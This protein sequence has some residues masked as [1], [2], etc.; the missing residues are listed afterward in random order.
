MVTIT[1][2]LE[3]GCTEDKRV[4]IGKVSIWRLKS[5]MPPL[6]NFYSSIGPDTSM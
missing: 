3:K 4:V 2:D 5:E 6:F 1:E